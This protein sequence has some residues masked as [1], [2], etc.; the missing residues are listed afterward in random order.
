MKFTIPEGYDGIKIYRSTTGKDGSFKLK[1]TKTSGTS[2]INTGLTTGNT[3][4]YK[5]RLYKVVEG[6]KVYTPYSDVVKE[7]A[8]PAKVS[9][10]T[11]KKSSSTVKLTWNSVKGATGYDI[12]VKKSSDSSFKLLKAGKSVKGLVL[13]ASNLTDTKAVCDLSGQGKYVFKVRAYRV[14]NG[15]K[16]PGFCSK[17]VT[18]KI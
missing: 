7:K 10:L 5:A 15:V 4:Y 9:G 12:Y 1:T 11:A 14:V 8:R 17:T 3:Y 6:K 16:I 18:L 13:R 2:Y